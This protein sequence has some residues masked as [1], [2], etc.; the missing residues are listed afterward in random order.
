MDHPKCTCI[1]LIVK[2]EDDA[3]FENSGELN[4]TTGE[5]HAIVTRIWGFMYSHLKVKDTTISKI[6]YR[7]RYGHGA[8][9]VISC[10]VSNAQK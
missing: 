1:V 4:K 2:Q 8:I 10:D 3:L 9:V 5:K 7:T 6:V